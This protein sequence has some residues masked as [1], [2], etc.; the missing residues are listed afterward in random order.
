MSPQLTQKSQ[1]ISESVLKIF[2]EN[3]HPLSEQEQ[4]LDIAR[5]LIINANEALLHK[6][7]VDPQLIFSLSGDK[8]EDLM[9]ELFDGIG[10]SVEQT[11]KTRDG[12]VD[13]IAVKSLDDVSLR[14]LI[15]LKRY[16]PTRKVGVT[17]VRSL[18]GVKHHLGASK[19]IIATTSDFT[20][21]ATMFAD[22]HKWDLELKAFEGIM[23]WV[24]LYRKSKCPTIVST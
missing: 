17:L 3:W 9:A 12:G 18:Y 16:S 8:F 22:A 5:P 6:I 7:A 2:Y 21:P 1:Q 15:E 23:K 24:T 10:Y 19:A 11:Q 20:M 4:Q 13:I 14:F